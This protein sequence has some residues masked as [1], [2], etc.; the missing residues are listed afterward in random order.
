MKTQYKQ[1]YQSEE[2]FAFSKDPKYSP[3]TSSKVPQPFNKKNVLLNTLMRKL[4]KE[5]PIPGVEL[6]A[7]FYPTKW[8]PNIVP[9]AGKNVAIINIYKGKAIIHIAT[10][11]RSPY[12]AL[13]NLG[14]EYMHAI[15]AYTQDRDFDKEHNELEREANDFGFD[16]AYEFIKGGCK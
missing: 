9:N 5:Y 4:E 6:T 12:R 13:C 16:T 11:E 8:L 15:Q 14:H 2:L 3:I 7:C 1:K 10:R